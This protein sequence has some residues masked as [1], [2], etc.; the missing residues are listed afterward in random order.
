MKLGF[1]SAWF[2]HFF[3]GNISISNSVTEHEE[4]GG[5]KKQSTQFSCILYVP[6][7]Y[8]LFE[9]SIVVVVVAISAR[10]IPRGDVQIVSGMF[11]DNI[12]RMQLP[13]SALKANGSELQQ[14]KDH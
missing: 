7:M 4:R 13:T 9:F 6:D 11:T 12:G 8:D 2:L 10:C 5:I 3:L 14:V 1:V